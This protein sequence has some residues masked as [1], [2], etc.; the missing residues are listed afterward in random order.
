MSG[1]N[2]FVDASAVVDPRTAIGGDCVVGASTTIGEK[3]RVQKS[4]VGAHCKIGAQVKIV[5]SVVLDHVT[6]EDG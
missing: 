3:C 6:I 4:V 2:N 5:N 1:K